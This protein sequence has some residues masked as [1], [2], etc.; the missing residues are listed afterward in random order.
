MEDVRER[1]SLI[2]E[3]S[4]FGFCRSKKSD[5][6]FIHEVTNDRLEQQE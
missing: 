2:L 6:R 3:I 1:L 4:K 5:K